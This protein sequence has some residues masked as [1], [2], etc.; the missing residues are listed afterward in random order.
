MVAL[1]CVVVVFILLVAMTLVLK[2]LSSMFVLLDKSG[3]RGGR[4]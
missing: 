3:E 2:I 4:R 1:L